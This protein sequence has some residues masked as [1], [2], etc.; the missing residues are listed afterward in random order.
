MRLAAPPPLIRRSIVRPCGEV[1]RDPS[2]PSPPENASATRYIPSFPE[3]NDAAGIRIWPKGITDTRA[4]RYHLSRD[5][6]ADRPSGQA[7]LTLGWDS[8][9]AMRPRTSRASATG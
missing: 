6:D 1:P 8:C 3:R 4:L 7:Q 9:D 2:S 5:D